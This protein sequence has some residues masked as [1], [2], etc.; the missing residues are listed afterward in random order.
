MNQVYRRAVCVV[1][2]AHRQLFIPLSRAT[3]ARIRTPYSQFAFLYLSS[4]PPSFSFHYFP[5]FL[6]RFS[7]YF[8]P[9]TTPRPADSVSFPF[10][11][12]L[13]LSIVCT[14][15]SSSFFVLFYS[16][17]ALVTSNRISNFSTPC[18]SLSFLRYPL[19]SVLEASFAVP[20]SLLFA[21]H[22]LST[23][24]TRQCSSSHRLS[25]SFDP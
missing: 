14:R 23:E 13:P 12:F 2:V 21:S 17:G 25:Y 20:F 6:F 16:F 4:D 19:H 11:I 1:P 7:C 24:Y 5:R 8:K 9:F 3:A 10:I 18:F 15:Y 22:V